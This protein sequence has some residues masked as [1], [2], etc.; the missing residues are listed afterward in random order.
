[1]GIGEKIESAMQSS[2]GKKFMAYL[3]GWGAS[4]VILGALFK[5]QHYPGAGPMLIVGLTTEAIIFFFSVFEPVHEDL[6]WGLVYPEL[7]HMD[8]EDE[9]LEEG[10]KGYVPKGTVTEQ[11][12]RMLE[13]AKIG[14]EL[15][16]SLSQGMRSLSDNTSK[17][18][19]LSD[20][21]IA[22]SEYS[23]KVKQASDSL[24]TLNNAYSQGNQAMQEL[25]GVSSN[26]KDNLSNIAASSNQYSESMQSASGKMVEMNASYGN[27]INALDEIAASS[28]T[29]RDY[30]E[31]MGKLTN[32]LSSLNSIY[33]V[34]LMESNSKLMNSINDLSATSEASR[35]LTEQMQQLTQS[36]GSLNS[37]YSSEVDES[38][39]RSEAVKEFYTGINEVMQNLQQSAD[40]VKR[41]RDEVSKLGDNLAALNNIY[42]NM[43]AAMN[44]GAAPGASQE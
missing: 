43:L 19:D 3:Y 32:N 10:D 25:A 11:L 29:A 35:S 9:E 12:D 17:L 27:A 2:R 33:E 7:A 18:S 39:T 8:P 6:D 5:I 44:V 22:T 36:V 34:D 41:S 38:R 1:M 21:S 23:D 31:Q 20:A 13:N 37:S 14:P 4:V 15:I 26:V 16:G 42:G 28:G 40:G 24:G 30:N